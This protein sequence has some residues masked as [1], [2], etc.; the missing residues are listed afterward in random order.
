MS[1][2]HQFR[3]DGSKY[4][5]ERRHGGQSEKSTFYKCEGILFEWMILLRR[6]RVEISY[7]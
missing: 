1:E 7:S 4:L 3:F 6:A 2:I 5:G